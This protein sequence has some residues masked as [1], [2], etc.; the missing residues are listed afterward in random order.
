M[1]EILY[2]DKTFLPFWIKF[3]SKEVYMYKYLDSVHVRV[4]RT[5]LK[6]ILDAK[7]YKNIED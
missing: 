3:R 6:K 4:S 7:S 1:F 5:Q 2:W